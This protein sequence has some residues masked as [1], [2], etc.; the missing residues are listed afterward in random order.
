M[1]YLR[2]WLLMHATGHRVSWYLAGRSFEYSSVSTWTLQL[3]SQPL[4]SNALHIVWFCVVSHSCL[5]FLTNKTELCYLTGLFTTKS[6]I[7]LALKKFPAEIQLFFRDN[8]NNVLSQITKSNFFKQYLAKHSV[9]K[10]LTEFLESSHYWKLK[11]V[12]CPC[13]N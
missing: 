2:L 13:Y 1:T 5:D 8:N 10:L 6:S 4:E 11:F 12:L 3:Q 7:S 9:V